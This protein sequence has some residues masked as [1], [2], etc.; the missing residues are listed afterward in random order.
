MMW[1][2]FVNKTQ[3]FKQELNNFT[4]KTCWPEGHNMV[5]FKA[6]YLRVSLQMSHKYIAGVTN[7]TIVAMNQSKTTLKAFT[8]IIKT[9]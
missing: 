4:N 9:F 1:A 3:R 7:D 5:V 2:L 8:C 6:L